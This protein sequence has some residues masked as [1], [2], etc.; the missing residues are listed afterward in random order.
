[1]TRPNI[2]WLMTDEQRPDSIGCYGSAWAQTPN[3]DRL[4]AGGTRFDTAIVPSPVCIPSRTSI[5]AAAYPHTTGTWTN[6][7]NKQHQTHL[8]TPFHEA[9]YRSASFGKQHY[10]LAA[11]AFQEQGGV[12]EGNQAVGCLDYREPYHGDDFE[13]VQYPG[14]VKWIL[15]GRYPEDAASRC[16]YQ[17]VDRCIAWLQEHDDDTPFLLRASFAGP[18]TPVVPPEPFDRLVQDDDIDLPPADECRFPEACPW[19]IEEKLAATHA[20]AALDADQIRR[21][22]RHY[23]GNVAFLDQQFGRLLTWMEQRGLLQN[24]I[25]AFCSDHGTCLGDHGLVQKESFFDQVVDVGFILTPPP[26]M[27]APRGQALKTPVSV[28]SLLPTLL[29]LCDLDVPAGAEAPSLAAAVRAGAEP[30][31]RPVL[32]EIS[33]GGPRLFCQRNG[34]EQPEIDRERS[35]HVMVRDGKWKLVFTVAGAPAEPALFDLA[36]DPGEEHNLAGQPEHQPVVDRLLAVAGA[37]TP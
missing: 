7:H 6:E 26:G 24:T 5:L 32:S 23:Y 16:E 11:N 19:W 21:M 28:M 17:V 37:A 20:A 13:Q 12:S 31:A 18:H 33:L 29:E 8:L 1:M 9:G 30:E 22:R 10:D 35:H 34:I 4:A 36:A 14:P 27:D 2:L 25:I 3:L 15:G